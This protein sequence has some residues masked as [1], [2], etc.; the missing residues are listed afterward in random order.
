MRFYLDAS[1]L[2]AIV[3][4]EPSSQKVFDAIRTRDQLPLISDFCWAECS[5]ALAKRF[6][7][8][9]KAATEVDLY[10]ADLDQWALEGGEPVRITSDDID[11]AAVQVRRPDLVLR[12][13]DAI[14]IMAAQRLGA[15]L[16]TL[17]KGMARA[18]IALGVAYINPADA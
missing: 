13:P 9:A 15:T 16:L 14:H 1:A 8:G 3:A 12:A 2:V 5:A 6:R 7:T 10:H 18:A 17:D 4:D 11:R